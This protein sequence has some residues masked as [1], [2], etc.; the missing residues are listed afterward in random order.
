MGASSILER[1]VTCVAGVA[2]PQLPAFSH[3]LGWADCSRSSSTGLWAPQV[4]KNLPSPFPSP[5]LPTTPLYPAHHCCCPQLTWE[6]GKAAPHLLWA[7]RRDLLAGAAVPGWAW[8]HVEPSWNRQEQLC[9]SPLNPTTGSASDISSN[10]WGREIGKG[11]RNVPLS[12]EGKEEGNSYL[13]RGLKSLLLL[14]RHA[15]LKGNASTS[16]QLPDLPLHNTS[17]EKALSRGRFVS[18]VERTPSQV[19][20][21]Y[22][23]RT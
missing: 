12:T 13:L 1:S 8:L 23:K 4:G 9:S 19:S 17:S 3:T 22:F 14:L 10:E 15:W 18:K 21:T 7:G 11:R 16:L 2:A 20:R 6:R 5:L